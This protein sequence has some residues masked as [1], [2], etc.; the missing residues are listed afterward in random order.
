MDA[1]LDAYRT[2]DALEL[3]LVACA[4][5]SVWCWFA[6][7]VTGNYSQVDRL[8]SI[9]P[10]LYTFRFAVHGGFADPRLSIMTTLVLLWDTRL[11]Y[12]F[13]RKG[14]WGVGGEDYR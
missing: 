14:G 13:A 10:V 12:N 7:I 1:L 11:T 6:S 5:L 4:L 8:W 9:L 2:T 3:A